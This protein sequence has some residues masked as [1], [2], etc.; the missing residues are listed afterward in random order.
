MRLEVV[1]VL[2][3]V[4]L[5][6]ADARA[7]DDSADQAAHRTLQVHNATA[8][9]V[10]LAQV[11]QPPALLPRPVDYNW[12]DKPGQHTAAEHIPAQLAAFGQAAGHNR[13]RR[14]RECPLEQ[15]VPPEPLEC[16]HGLPVGAEPIALATAVRYALATHLPEQSG[17]CNVQQVFNEYVCRIFGTHCAHF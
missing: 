13:G 3:V 8:R 11:G 17:E 4:L 15:P 10:G 2:L 12:V 9:E 1:L 5:E 7:E 6:P 16:R 14:A